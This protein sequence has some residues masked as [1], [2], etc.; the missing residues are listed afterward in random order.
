MARLQIIRQDTANESRVWPYDETLE[1]GLGVGGLL[2]L[3][4]NLVAQ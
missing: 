3:W 1:L 2:A 4:P